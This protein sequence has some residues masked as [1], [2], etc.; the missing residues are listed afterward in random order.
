MNTN[1]DRKD[2]AERAVLDM[3]LAEELAGASPPDLWSRL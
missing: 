3:A 2:D 1:D